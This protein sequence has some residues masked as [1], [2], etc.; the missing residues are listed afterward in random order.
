MITVTM[1]RDTAV[2]LAA[3]SAVAAAASAGAYLAYNYAAK[4]TADVVIFLDGSSSKPGLTLPRQ[5]SVA[6]LIAALEQELH[7]T[8]PRL[9]LLQ[10]SVSGS[11]PFP[12]SPHA[13][14]HPSSAALQLLSVLGH[15][16]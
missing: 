5:D 8:S 12:R 11:A 3:G 9:F 15:P 14:W 10:V 2:A 13:P 7:I 4:Q 6:L 16:G 1:T